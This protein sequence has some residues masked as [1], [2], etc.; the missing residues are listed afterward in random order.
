[1]N[2]FNRLRNNED[3]PLSAEEGERNRAR[4]VSTLLYVVL[5]AV[6]VITGAHAVLLVINTTAEY[7]AEGS[8][9]FV[10][11]LNTIRVAFPL[12]VEVA[13]VAVGLG[14]IRSRWRAGQRGIGTAL[15]I[16]WFLFAAANMITFFAL[17][18]GDTL[19]GWQSAW[20]QYGLPLSALIIAAM[21][22][23]IL[24]ADPAHLRA[25]EEALAQEK[26]RTA[27]FN[28][29]QAVKTSDA[30]MT[31]IERRVWR[32]EV[33]AMEVQGF[34]PDEIDFMTGNIPTLNELAARRD[35][36]A[37]QPGAAQS[38]L[39]D[40]AAPRNAWRTRVFGRRAAASTP[41]N[42]APRHVA[43]ATPTPA[44]GQG[45]TTRLHPD[46][47]AAIAAVL[48]QMTAPAPVPAAVHA[49]GQEPNQ[50]PNG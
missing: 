45:A 14:F 47:I 48:S 42:D 19:Q 32:D 9:L 41:A 4:G 15:E 1:M 18:R 35:T 50:R 30:M 37:A 10:T 8:G 46:D 6:V 23:L 34:D 12:I 39:D 29:R 43:D 44:P 7:V 17:E 33:R 40:N 16:A 3:Y 20:V 5:A 11:L 22:Y 26:Q 24:K 2:W 31:V 27:E 38:E 28:T 25:N 13:A 49:N 36:S 21:T